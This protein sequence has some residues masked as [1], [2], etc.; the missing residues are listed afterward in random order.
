VATSEELSRADKARGEYV[1]LLENEVK[2]L[3]Q[4]VLDLQTRHS[5]EIS[6]IM[7]QVTN[8]QT[9]V[10]LVEAAESVCQQER[11]TLLNEN[12]LLRRQLER[13]NPT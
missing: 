13:G 8:L 10:R 7:S 11:Q 9:R 2:F 6:E 12:T 5:A 4:N 3:R 1:T